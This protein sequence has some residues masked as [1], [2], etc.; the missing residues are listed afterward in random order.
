MK[1][2]RSLIFPVALV[3][4]FFVFGGGIRSVEA[5]ETIWHYGESQISSDTTWHSGEV[6][7]ISD[8][9]YIWVKPGFTLIIEPGVVVK[10]GLNSYFRINGSLV[11]NGSADNLIYFV[12]LRDDAVAG[13]TNGDGSATSAVIND[14][15]YIEVDGFRYGS[16]AQAELSY[17]VIKHGGRG[18]PRGNI[19]YVSKAASFKIDHSNIIDNSGVIFVDANSNNSSITNSNLYNPACDYASST[20]PCRD[21]SGFQTFSSKTIDLINNYWGSA[22]GPT[23]VTSSDPLAFNGTNLINVAG[24]TM[25]YQ[26]WATEP[27]EFGAKKLDP[28]VVIPGIMGSWKDF[29]G[30]WQI[31]PILHTYDDLLEALRAVGYVDGQTLFTFPYE[32]RNSNVITAELLRQKISEIKTATGA[33]KVDLI[34]HSMGGLVARAYIQGDSYQNDVDQMI[35]IATPHKGAPASYLMWEGGEKG[36]GFKNMA[37]NSVFRVEAAEHGF[38]SLDGKGVVQY[39]RAEHINSA[40]ELLPIYSY[41]FDQKTNKIRL[42]S[43]NYPRNEFLEN[44]NST[45]SLEKLDSVD[46]LNILGDTGSDTINA[47]FVVTSTKPLPMWENGMPYAYYNLSGG[48][49]LFKGAGDG[50]VPLISNHN[51]NSSTELTIKQ[52]H[53]DIVSYS[54]KEVI[55]ELTGQEPATEI[56]EFRLWNLLLLAM[57]S[58][59]DFQIIAPDGKIVGR[60]FNSSSTIINEIPGAFYSGFNAS[61]TPEFVAIPNPQDGDYQ[62]KA[63][64]VDG[65][66]SYTV[67]A[68]YFSE[69]S[70]TNTT[71]TGTIASGGQEILAFAVASS[72]E[73]LLTNLKSTVV[74]VQSTIKDLNWV[75]ANKLL[76]NKS[77]NQKLYQKY[78]LLQIKVQPFE[79]AKILATN[80]RT[81]LNSNVYLNS[82]D[83]AQMIAEAEAYLLKIQT[84]RQAAIAS[85][86]DLLDGLLTQLLNSGL[87]KQQGYDIMKEDNDYLRNNW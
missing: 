21:D 85:D 76:T 24:G 79:V 58:P 33:A 34:G 42:Y 22:G 1:N 53:S 65:G 6:H 16:V 14:W 36:P 29:S 9:A 55:R 25:N 80:F 75:Y 31:D 8:G 69:T 72:S 73:A 11:A 78:G 48:S 19:F 81:N 64:G 59:A 20:D 47:L 49:G 74:T 82:V 26:P 87:L 68:D 37:L 13:D 60:D 86:L 32:W 46:V 30:T 23:Y 62:I 27:F 2:F 51:F 50:T 4:G 39:L 3:A 41:I 7:A 44:L 71:Y 52:E 40:K 10:I 45:S 12:S 38:V 77:A 66:G 70:S 61:G 18:F 57:H 35:F 54:Q 28:V 67:T 43:N 15:R 17:A 5:T 56:Y 63:L 84:D 83:K